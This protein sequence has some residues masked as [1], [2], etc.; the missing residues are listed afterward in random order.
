MGVSAFRF[1]LVAANYGM[2][3]LDRSVLRSVGARQDKLGVEEQFDQTL[4][5]ARA[6]ARSSNYRC[7]APF[8]IA[9][10]QRMR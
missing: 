7:V 10:S 1:F 4:A 8:F 6:D 2:L 5:T 3:R 9:Y